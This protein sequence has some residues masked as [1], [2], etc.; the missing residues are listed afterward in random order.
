MSCPIE[1]ARAAISGRSGVLPLL[2]ARIPTGEHIGRRKNRA[3]IS[4]RRS[5]ILPEIPNIPDRPHLGILKKIDVIR[6][7]LGDMR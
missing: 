6:G 1:T 3:L 7:L 4:R 2:T 5:K